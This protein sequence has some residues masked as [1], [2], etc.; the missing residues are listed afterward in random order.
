VRNQEIMSIDLG[1]AYTK[2]A[3]RTGW[4]TDAALVHDM[5]QASKEWT[6]CFP[7]LVAS[8]KRGNDETWLIG[9]AASKL[10]PGDGVRVYENWKPGLLGLRSSLNA[11]ESGRAAVQ[12][13]RSLRENFPLTKLWDEPGK[14][15]V[16]ISVPK[17]GDGRESERRIVEVL[18]EAGWRSAKGRITVYEPESNALGVLTRGRNAT[19]LP[20][21][22]TF[23]PWPDRSAL[24]PRMLEPGLQNAFHN[25]EAGKPYGVLVIDVGAFT[26]D[27]GFAL[28]DTSFRTNDWNKPEIAQQSYEL[29]IRDLDA[30]V[31]S[32]LAPDVQA[33]IQRSPE[34]MWETNKAPLYGGTQVAFRNPSGGMLVVG[35]GTDAKSI[36]QAVGSFSQR[37][38]Q[39]RNDFCKGHRFTRIDAQILTG[40]GAMIG[41]IREAVTSAS[42]DGV[43]SIHDLLDEEE[44]RRVVGSLDGHPDEAGIEARRRQNVELVRGGSAIGGCSV[45]FE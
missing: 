33:A 41:T 42:T 20:P 37:V 5:A 35:G 34:A 22:Q 21:Y 14:L 10:I 18:R 4:N 8:V 36:R 12:F 19:W 9:N 17:L 44:P 2:V 38:V 3:L 32:G 27:F 43:E 26:T 28:F 6:F 30:A 45:F 13:F 25:W 7:S 29:G 39:A 40:G 31:R 23:R 1:S 24:L 16:R 15:P 11:E